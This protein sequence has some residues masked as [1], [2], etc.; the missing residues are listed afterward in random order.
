MEATYIGFNMW[1]K[2]IKKAGTTDP[3]KV[4]DALIGI[5]VPNLTGGY[6]ATLRPIT[7]CQTVLIGEIQDD[8]QFGVVSETPAGT[9]VGDSG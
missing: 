3:A 1:V 4:Q 7:T 8:G 5:S 2:A 6:A 9:V